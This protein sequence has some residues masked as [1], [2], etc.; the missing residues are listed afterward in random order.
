MV[1]MKTAFL[2]FAYKQPNHLVKLV[3]ALGGD[4][5]RFFIHVDKKVDDFEFRKLAS[6]NS[7]V[8]FLE[9]RL[10]TKVYWGGFG[11]VQATLN[12][13][14]VSINSGWKFERFCLLTESDFP[15]K[16]L[17][18]IRS[19]FDSNKEFIRIDDRINNPN[20]QFFKKLQCYHF[21]GP[22]SKISG[23]GLMV[24]RKIY[25]SMNLYKGSSYW[26]LTK[27]C[28]DFISEFLKHN[29]DLIQF[30]KHT[31]CPDEILVQTIIKNSPFAGNIT[32]DFER[33]D[34]LGKFRSGNVHGG[35]Y[36]D[37]NSPG[38]RLPKVLVE[39][40]LDDLLTSEAV[41]A[42]KFIEGESDLLL[43]KLKNALRK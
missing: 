23:N 10:R 11:H 22:F 3:S 40:D 41:F 5:A 35:H 28:V 31:F 37:W 15:I 18:E 19:K 21:D 8:I 9:D 12:L 14:E 6:K 42:R 4:W 26:A 38:V 32:H 2:I 16:P 34:D 36:I 39:T 43:E 30:L 7:E 1:R 33:T 20:N 24:H 25:N 13:L 17:D 29:Q 27:G